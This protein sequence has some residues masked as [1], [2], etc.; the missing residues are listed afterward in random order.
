MNRNLSLCAVR[1]LSPSWPTHFFTIKWLR[2]KQHAI[3]LYTSCCTYHTNICIWNSFRMPDEVSKRQCRQCKRC[4]TKCEDHQRWTARSEP[5]QIS[6]RRC[7]THCGNTSALIF[8]ECNTSATLWT[9]FIWNALP[10]EHSVLRPFYLRFHK[11]TY[12]GTSQCQL[13]NILVSIQNRLTSAIWTSDLASSIHMPVIP[14]APHKYAIDGYWLPTLVDHGW[15]IPAVP[16]ALCHLSASGDTTTMAR[17]C[18][19]PAICTQPIGRSD[20]V[21]PSR[22][23]TFNTFP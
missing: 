2:H 3:L 20:S 15:S 13:Q 11:N 12:C 8:L 17:S 1:D 14:I 10:S 23:M 19:L 16:V 21:S 4:Q 5:L 18:Q 22:K 9:K 6:K 7:E